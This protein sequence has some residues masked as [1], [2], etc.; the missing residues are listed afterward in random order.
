MLTLGKRTGHVVANS[1]QDF[2]FDNKD[3]LRD[4][5]IDSAGTLI[6]LISEDK[7]VQVFN[8]ETK[9]LL[10]KKYT[11]KR[12]NKIIFSYD[13]NS[14]L[15]ADKFGDVYQFNIH[16]KEIENLEDHGKFLCGHV[17]MISDMFMTNDGKHLIT[18][19]RDEKIRISEYP[20]CYNIHGYCLG[21]DQFISNMTM[22]D[23]KY[24]LSSGGDPY[25]ILWD[26]LN[27]NEIQR[28]DFKSMLKDHPLIKEDTF[29]NVKQTLFNG[30]D[31]IGI[32]M[33]NLPI[34][35]LLN[36]SKE[37]DSFNFH[38]I[39]TLPKE[40]WEFV[41]LDS[42]HIILTTKSNDHDESIALVYEFKDKEW[43]L[44]SDNILSNIINSIRKEY[45]RPP[46]PTQLDEFPLEYYRKKFHIND[47]DAE[48]LENDIPNRLHTKKKLKV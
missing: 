5:T 26:L 32:L 3:R 11:A 43:N 1:T 22:L 40:S 47:P 25:L 29:F 21:H 45:N 14:V 10:L 23:E 12:A 37:F 20:K 27:L 39:I 7:S 31:T 8:I 6:A 42:T 15:V 33:D 38:S 4:F 24:V 9:T 36:V 35:I 2:Q 13:N 46:V 17:S 28:I 41:F 18:S 48:K 19:D 30:K 16:E 34:L 44:H